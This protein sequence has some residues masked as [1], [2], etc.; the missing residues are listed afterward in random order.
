MSVQLL[1]RA[2]LMAEHAALAIHALLGVVEGPAVF[3]LEESIVAADSR[4]RQFF[5]SVSKTA[6]IFVPA[7]SCFNP[8]LAKLGFVL[9]IWVALDWHHWSV[10]D[11]IGEGLEAHLLLL[12]EAR[13]IV[14]A[15]RL[16]LAWREILYANTTWLECRSTW[17]ERRC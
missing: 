2:M 16:L 12:A 14:E 13:L 6:F 3:G 10:L 9:A 7:L 4:L 17:D 15:H 1:E 5:L 8:V 11:A